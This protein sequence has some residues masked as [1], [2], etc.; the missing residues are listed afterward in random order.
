MKRIISAMLVILMLAASC[1]ALVSCG[2]NTDA[3]AGMQLV[4]GSDAL[5]YYFYA[6]EEWIVSNHGDIACTYTSKLNP[7]TVTF[8][9]AAMPE[10]SIKEYFD[11]E[12]AKYPDEFK[13]KVTSDIKETDFGN[14]ERAY[15]AV[16][17][18]TYNGSDR[19]SM[20]IFVIHE[21]RFFIFTYASYAAQYNSESTYY[22]AF[23]EKV[24]GIIKEFKFVKVN[25]SES[26][27]TPEYPKDKDGYSLVSDKS[28]AH[29]DLYIPDTYSVDYSTSIVSVSRE[30]GTNINVSEA[31]YSV[32]L[33]SVQYWELRLKELEIIAD[34]VKPLSEQTRFELDGASAVSYEYEYR[35]AG[36]HIKVYQVL[37]TTPFHGFVFTYSAE[38]DLY[39]EH[40]DEAKDILN[41]IGF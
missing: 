41:R 27:D 11:S 12:M 15:S 6:P 9:E 38:A 3:P 25:G 5:G 40:L 1:T 20:Q 22:E 26:V 8:V 36:K 31:T 29:F 4:R 24:L 39:A 28:I 34:D 32:E 21:G 33:T 30:D 2:G 10:V 35:M 37:M 7:S 16:F 14:A 17:S 19:I 18:Y 13:A 23:L